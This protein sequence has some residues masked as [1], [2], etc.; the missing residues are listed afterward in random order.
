MKLVNTSWSLIQRIPSKCTAH[1][2]IPGAFT[3][4]NHR[5]ILVH[6]NR[7]TIDVTLRGT[8]VTYSNVYE[9]IKGRN[10]F[11][12]YHIEPTR[13]NASEALVEYHF[14][15][16]DGTTLLHTNCNFLFQLPELPFGGG[17]PLM[18]TL[19]EGWHEKVFPS[20]LVG[21]QPHV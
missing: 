1:P 11:Y 14:E 4:S 13:H 18:F 9:K 5:G 3:P 21:S 2:T 6:F 10:V 20:T 19:V 12:A 15:P 8:G 7:H 16:V 17:H